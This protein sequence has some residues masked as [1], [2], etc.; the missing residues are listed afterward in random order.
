MISPTD[1][2]KDIRAKRKIY[3]A[4]GILLWEVYRE[5]QTVDVYLPNQAERIEYGIDDVLDA[6]DV[7]PGF[8]LAVRDIFLK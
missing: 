6:G 8:T 4:A 2:A 7:I 1:K 3:Q 5:D